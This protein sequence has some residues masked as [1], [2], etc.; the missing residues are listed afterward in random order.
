M[1]F[2]LTSV[3]VV[4]SGLQ[5]MMPNISPSRPSS[6]A[7]ISEETCVH[8]SG[9]LW[10][11]LQKCLPENLTME[12][13]TGA[14]KSENVH[15]AQAIRNC[16]LI[17]W[18]AYLEQYPDVKAA[19]MDPVDH[20]L[21]Y[22][23]L[24]GRKLSSHKFT[25]PVLTHRQPEPGEVLKKQ[26]LLQLISVY[27][28]PDVSLEKL[29]DRCDLEQTS[30]EDILRSSPWL[31]WSSYTLHYSDVQEAGVDPVQH[32][33]RHGV[34]EG[35]KLFSYPEPV[36]D[37][38][39]NLPM[40]SVIVLN[41]DN[42][43]YLEKCLNSLI[44][45]TLDQIEIIIVDDASTD[46]SLEIIQEF[47]TGDKRLRLIAHDGHQG[48]YM[49]RKHGVEAATGQ[50]IMFVD[51][52]DF[53]TPNACQ[54]A[55][56]TV[57][58]GYDLATFKIN[59]IN[60]NVLDPIGE[61]LLIATNNK[62]RSGIYT[63]TDTLSMAFEGG[64]IP[65]ALGTKIGSAQV[66]KQAFA[67]LEDGYYPINGEFYE[68]LAIA[69]IARNMRVIDAQLYNLRITESSDRDDADYWQC[70]LNMIDIL[71]PI[72]R[73][74]LVHNLDYYLPRVESV[75]FNNSAEKLINKAPDHLIDSWL[76]KLANIYGEADVVG[77]LS[78]LYFTNW[79]LVAERLAKCP[80]LGYCPKHPPKKVGIFYHAL[81][82][83][84]VEATIANLCRLLPQEGF[85]VV[86]FVER[87][88]EWDSLYS[89]SA[90]Y[91]IRG[92]DAR[93]ED[94]PG[95]IS[96][97]YRAVKQSGI[98]VMLNFS[99]IRIDL[100]WDVLLLRLMGIQIIGRMQTG[101]AH[102]AIFMDKPYNPNPY[103]LIFK[104]MDRVIC[105]S[106]GAECYYTACGINAVFIPNTIRLFS[107]DSAEKTEN[108]V[109][110]IAR[111][112]DKWKR[113]NECLKILVDLLKLVP[114]A[115][116]IFIG[117]FHQ[118][119]EAD[120]FWYAVR[121][122]G[123]AAHVLVSG[124]IE[125][126]GRY[127]DKAKVLLSTSYMEGFPNGIAE[128]Q[129]RGMPVVMYDLDI[130]MAW[131]N[132]A[133]IRVPQGAHKQAALELAGLMKNALLCKRLGNLARAKSGEYSDER[134]RKNYTQL[135]SSLSQNARRELL[136]LAIYQHTIRNFTNYAG[137][138]LPA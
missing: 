36:S 103:H 5:N 66:Y 112:G 38:W 101:Y 100:F 24:E 84:G 111:L 13:I 47:C 25:A 136:P 23:I 42:A 48:S 85:E 11:L 70:T 55:W 76:K 81:T 106:K 33:L 67:R 127:L 65:V 108:T 99:A 94:I 116:M 30:V 131:D 124:W 118:K 45:Q 137:R 91:Y 123:L 44:Q 3:N 121:G 62:V 71:E 64:R 132:P 128:A 14:N 60:H 107:D 19:G 77:R 134:F 49:A 6:Q 120:K 125:E 102:D 135:L 138:G 109:A 35:R 52:K 88:T 4:I 69:S 86:L 122:M 97:L 68:F 83:G 79:I 28:P 130:E 74:C 89:A 50:Y 133:I 22:G 119:K 54:V 93:Q 117:G 80:K 18:E 92:S 15:L 53:Y 41:Y 87:Q 114:D 75:L 43:L 39:A 20:F 105:L 2:E 26:K 56:E 7:I 129:A 16:A 9:A 95:H 98:D 115:R 72:R 8:G 40:V 46:D 126:V 58:Q 1:I 63:F 37:N 51:S 57:A 21:R 34:F 73:Y 31:N 96:D 59:F 12:E 90:I 29:I 82:P 113:T 32:F 27:L 104:C 10:Q 78:Q 61:S 17:N 110:V